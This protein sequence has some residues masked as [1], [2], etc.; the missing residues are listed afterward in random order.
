MQASARGLV[1]RVELPTRVF[2]ADTDTNLRR[3]ATEAQRPLAVLD[4][5]LRGYQDLL[6]AGEKGREKIADPRWEASYDLAVGRVLAMRVRAYGYNAMLAAMKSSPKTFEKD[7]NNEWHLNPAEEI[8]TGPQVRKMAEKARELL[9]RVTERHAGTP[10]AALAQRELSQPFGWEWSE[11]RNER[12]EVENGMQ[13]E[14]ARLLFEEEQERKREA[15]K[16]VV[17]PK[18]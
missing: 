12:Y 13:G 8:A 2:R 15:E 1:E 4:H 5:E 11:H 17:L 18:L 14:Q 9:T 3:A 7:G 6:E 16:K 10:W